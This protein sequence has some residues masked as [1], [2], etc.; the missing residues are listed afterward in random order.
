MRK[1]ASITLS[2]SAAIAA[3]KEG[4]ELWQVYSISW[5]SSNSYMR[6]QPQRKSSLNRYSLIRSIPFAGNWTPKARVMLR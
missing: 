5:V 3:I 1:M 6:W 4:A 2:I